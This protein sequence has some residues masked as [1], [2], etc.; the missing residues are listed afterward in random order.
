MKWEGYGEADMTW[1]PME[2]LMG[3][4]EQIREYEKVRAEQEKLEMERV[5]QKRKE[6]MEQAE[7]HAKQLREAASE[8]AMRK[9]GGVG[10]NASVDSADTDTA[11]DTEGSV[12]KV[13]KGKNGVVWSHFDLTKPKVTHLQVSGCRK[14]VH[15]S[16]CLSHSVRSPDTFCA[17]QYSAC[18][19]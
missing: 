6:A 2:H 11:R 5:V 17:L 4:A 19:V 15:V 13:H 18:T 12:L 8:A 14:Y 10:Q 3:C 7:A 1:E 9:A 16:S